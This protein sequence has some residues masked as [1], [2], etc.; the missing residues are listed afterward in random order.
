MRAID[1]F[2]AM[3]AGHGYHGIR[4]LGEDGRGNVRRVRVWRRADDWRSV[5]RTLRLLDEP[6]LQ[7][8]ARAAEGDDSWTV[9]GA[10]VVWART[11]T[12]KQQ[13]ALARFRPVPTLWLTEGDSVRSTALWATRGALKTNDA[14]RVS[15]HI[16]HALG[17]PKKFA[18]EDCLL[19]PP[20]ALLTEGRKRPLV[21]KVVRADAGA[22]Y[23][24]GEV[25]RRLPRQIPDPDAWLERKI[26]A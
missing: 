4:G 11:E 25:C 3:L 16:A 13:E 20:G 21:V 26:A 22:I 18:T 12:A 14:V 23:P 7:V 6:E 17:T 8:V 10:N 9:L 19:R 15:R 2:A 24:V 1:L 5:A